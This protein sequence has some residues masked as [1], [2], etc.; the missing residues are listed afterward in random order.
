MLANLTNNTPK[1]PIITKEQIA[2]AVE[3]YVLGMQFSAAEFAIEYR[4]G[5]DSYELAKVLEENCRCDFQRSDL[6]EIEDLIGHVENAQRELVKEWFTSNDIQPPYPI[7]SI[8]TKGEITGIYKYEPAYFEVKES[9]QL[10][11]SRRL[12]VRFEDA[13]L[14]ELSSVVP[15]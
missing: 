2:Q 9:G 3:K 11:Q 8:L 12:L 7:G 13:V 5:L 1:R 6:D 15:E 10:D 14:P 4:Y